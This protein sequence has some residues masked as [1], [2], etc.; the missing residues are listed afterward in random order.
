M[1]AREHFDDQQLERLQ[2][3][4]RNIEAFLEKV[5][6]LSGT[7]IEGEAL[8]VTDKT[9]AHRLGRRVRGLIVVKVSPNFSVGFSATQPSDSGFVNIKAGG[10]CTAS[11]WFW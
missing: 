1:S 10:N 7:L 11:L 4:I 5:P 2:T 9:I 6:F 8:S 3:R